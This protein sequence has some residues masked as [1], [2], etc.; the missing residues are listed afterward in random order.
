[1]A[2]GYLDLSHGLPG[3][4]QF[5]SWTC[6]TWQILVMAVDSWQFVPRWCSWSTFYY[7]S[8]NDSSPSGWILFTISDSCTLCW[9]Y[10]TIL[11]MTG[12]SWQFIQ[13]HPFLQYPLY[14]SPFYTIYFTLRIPTLF[15]ASCK[16]LNCQPLHYCA[17]SQD[18][19]EFPLPLFQASY[20]MRC[21]CTCPPLKISLQVAMATFMLFHRQLFISWIFGNSWFRW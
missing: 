13:N 16:P 21:Y 19:I 10:M 15:D 7:V 1:M 3:S 17:V 11:F 20:A 14:N 8:H 6:D 9:A 12:D 2:S 18:L 4:W 5:N